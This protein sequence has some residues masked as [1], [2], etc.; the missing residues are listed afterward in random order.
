MSNKRLSKLGTIFL[1]QRTFVLVYILVILFVYLFLIFIPSNLFDVCFSLSA[2]IYIVSTAIAIILT[3]WGK[4]IGR[5]VN[6]IFFK[7]QESSEQMEIDQK[8]IR[9]ILIAVYFV[10]I[11]VFTIASLMSHPVFVT[12]KMDYSIIQS[13]ATY[14][15]YDRLVRNYMSLIKKE[16]NKQQ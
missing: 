16:E 1:N 5:L 13:F 7:K 10:A 2:T 3:T 11:I 6:H 8:K 9:F 4:R 14:I 12:D 15:A